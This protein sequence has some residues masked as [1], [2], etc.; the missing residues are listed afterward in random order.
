MSGLYGG[1]GSTC[2]PYFS[3]ISDT[4]PEAWGRTRSASSQFLLPFQGSVLQNTDHVACQ[5]AHSVLYWSLA[6]NCR[7]NQKD[8]IILLAPRKRSV[9]NFWNDLRIYHKKHNKQRSAHTIDLLKIEA[10]PLNHRHYVPAYFATAL[11]QKL[12]R[13][14][15]PAT[16]MHH[17]PTSIQTWVQYIEPHNYSPD[18]SYNVST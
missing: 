8:C 10:V 12:L 14:A 15:H 4:A 3:K 16:Q 18:V 13:G 17:S 5:Y 11:L 2:Y 1:W 9:Q 6:H 7:E